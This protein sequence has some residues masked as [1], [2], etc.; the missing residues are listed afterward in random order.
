MAKLNTTAIAAAIRAASGSLGKQKSE[1]ERY[2]A[3]VEDLQG[4]FGDA[5]RETIKAY[6]CEYVAKRG[7]YTEG[8]W[9]ATAGT[10]KKRA[11]RIILSITG[12]AESAKVAVNKALVRQM[13]AMLKGME[14][15]VLNA[16]IAAVKAAL[17]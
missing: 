2:Q 1:K 12:K 10:S 14:V 8:K 4:L 5:D 15:K 13:T 3:L 6:V 7:E 17:K 9:A 16:T 11:N